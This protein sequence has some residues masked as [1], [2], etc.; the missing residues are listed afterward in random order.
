VAAEL[1]FLAKGR[2]ALVAFGIVRLPSHL[3]VLVPAA[4]VSFMVVGR[5]LAHA[6]P[7]QA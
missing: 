2:T 1:V 5:V 6:T 3:A 7:L 4:L